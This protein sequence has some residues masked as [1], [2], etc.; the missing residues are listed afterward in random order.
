V[1][2][3]SVDTWFLDRVRSEQARLRSYIRALG[4]RAEAVDDLAQ[5]ALVVALSKLGEF[6]RRNDFG[7]WVRQIA[8]R[9]VANE[10]RKETRRNQI[11]SEHVTDLLLGTELDSE[12]HQERL[13]ELAALR[14]CLAR[15]PRHSRELLHQRYFEDLSPG[16][17]SSRLGR[18]SN[19][20]RQAL[21]RLRRVL[22]GCI[23]RR[24]GSE[25]A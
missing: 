2:F 21:L 6:D 12:R 25:L 14:E 23:E 11:L 7:V 8:R 3:V 17:I 9:L 22:L 19:Q 1:P 20:V 16:A 4:V 24:I 18:T 10:L 13:E 5:E 15:L